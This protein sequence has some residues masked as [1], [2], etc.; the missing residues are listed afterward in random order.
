LEKHN[1]RMARAQQILACL[2]EAALEWNRLMTKGNFR[3][4]K[5]E[6]SCSMD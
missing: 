3:T 6:A 2:C 5:G 4:F 1:N